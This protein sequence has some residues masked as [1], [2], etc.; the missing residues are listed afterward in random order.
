MQKEDDKILYRHAY[1]Y[2]NL[3]ISHNAVIYV[4]KCYTT[5]VSTISIADKLEKFFSLYP[6]QSF[7]KGD[8]LIHAGESPAGIFYIKSGIV[9]NYWIS[10]EGNEVTL[11]MY[12][13]QTFL[14]MSWA[15][16]NVKNAHYYD[17][18]TEVCIHLAP[19]IDVLQFIRNEPDIMYDLL[20]RI[21]IG[22]EGLWMHLESISSGTAATK[23]MSSLVILAKRFGKKEG[24][25][26]RIELKMS[27]HDLANYAGMSRETASRELHKLKNE[28][29]VNFEKGIIH[30]L[31]IEKLEQLVLQ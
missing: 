3:T 31:D 20:R 19:K 23:L 5:H 8:I 24:E 12:K 15:I 22:M 7:Q 14:P 29:I 26:I 17:A 30:I 16:A 27:E 1:S 4:T 21:Y 28:K 10:L 13:P 25:G 18:M 6:L 2:Y 11:N 9:R